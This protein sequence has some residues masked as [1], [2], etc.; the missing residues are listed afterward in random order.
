MFSLSPPFP[1]LSL[2]LSNKGLLFHLCL[3]NPLPSTAITPVSLL[4]LLPSSRVSSIRVFFSR[5]LSGSR[6][7]YFPLIIYILRSFF[8]HVSSSV[9]LCYSEVYMQLTTLEY[10]LSICVIFCLCCVSYLAQVDCCLGYKNAR[11]D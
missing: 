1:F 3:P 6:L 5:Y 2:S 7:L 4:L 8:L 11:Q 9:I 10:H